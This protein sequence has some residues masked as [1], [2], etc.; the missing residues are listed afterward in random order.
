[1]P[2]PPPTINANNQPSTR[3]T[4]QIPQ[5]NVDT[6]LCVPKVGAFLY[7]EPHITHMQ[8]PHIAKIVSWVTWPSN[9]PPC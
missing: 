7:I 3:G 8:A 9:L 1:M 6:T 4:L 2:K 5:P